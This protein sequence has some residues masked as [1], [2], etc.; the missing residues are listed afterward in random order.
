MKRLI[1]FRASNEALFTGKR[2][3]AKI[4]WRYEPGSC[5]MVCGMCP[6]LLS[7]S[8]LHPLQH[9]PEGPGS[10][11]EAD[12]RPDRQEVGQP[13]DKVQG[14]VHISGVCSRTL[15]P[16]ETPVLTTT[17]IG[18]RFTP[19]DGRESHSE[20]LQQN[21]LQRVPQYQTFTSRAP[22]WHKHT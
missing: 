6:L 1:E 2:N 12:R 5:S 7:V 14:N 16:H 20:F 13:A 15:C 19:P 17:F 11:G 10:G 4:A 8:L 22:D 18:S 21:Y 9:H 3:S